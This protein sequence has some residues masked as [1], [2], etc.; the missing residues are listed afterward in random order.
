[1]AAHQIINGTKSD[2]NYI[3]TVGIN[4]D[5]QLVKKSKYLQVS[6]KEKTLYL[7]PEK[8]LPSWDIRATIYKTNSTLLIEINNT[9]VSRLVTEHMRREVSMQDDVVFKF[10]IIRKNMPDCLL[11][12]IDV[13]V[14]EL[15]NHGHVTVPLADIN[16][17]AGLDDIAIMTCRLFEHY[18]FVV[19]DNKYLGNDS[20]PA[21]Q[22][23]DKKWQFVQTDTESHIEF[24]QTGDK[25]EIKSIVDATQLTVAGL[26]QRHLTF[27]IVGD[28]PDEYYDH[29]TVNVNDLR[30]GKTTK[31]IIDFDIMDMNIIYRNQL[32]KVNKRTLY[33]TDTDQ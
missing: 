27:Y 10:Y 18:Y 30:M 28:T 3:V 1:L 7:L 26:H 6:Q 24:N 15:I 21:L 4:D 23:T 33:D 19:T 8:V 13:D 2:K 20:A 32:L 5:A 25:I 11:K 17:F 29:I 9:M 31:F 14:H 22:V 12:V 16:Q